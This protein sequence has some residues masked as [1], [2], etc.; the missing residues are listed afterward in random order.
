LIKPEPQRLPQLL[1][2]ARQE[3]IGILALGDGASAFLVT[4]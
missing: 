4:T 3:L 1:A 2:A